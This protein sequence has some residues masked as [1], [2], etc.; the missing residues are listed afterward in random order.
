[1]IEGFRRYASLVPTDRSGEEQAAEA[2][3]IE[4]FYR[5]RNL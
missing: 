5:V 3:G 2:G 4:E 1:M